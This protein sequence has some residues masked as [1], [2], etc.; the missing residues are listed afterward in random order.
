MMRQ[1][2]EAIVKYLNKKCK[3]DMDKARAYFRWLTTRDIMNL[4]LADTSKDDEN[5]VLRVWWPSKKTKVLEDERL[6]L[7]T[8]KC[9]GLKSLLLYH[10][11][12]SLSWP[13][14]NT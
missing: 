9:A 6:R 12:M 10:L 2:L 5:A 8:Q 13:K 1:P 14:M 4:I 11:I 7:Y 3:K